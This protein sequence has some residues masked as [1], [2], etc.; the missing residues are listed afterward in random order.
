M[1]GLKHAPA[2]MNDG[3]AIICASSMAAHINLP[4]QPRTRQVKS[5]D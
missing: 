3:G 1:L 2:Y 5:S 4:G